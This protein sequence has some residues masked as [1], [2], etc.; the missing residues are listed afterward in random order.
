[1][2]QLLNNHAVF[3]HKALNGLADSLIKIFIPI[4]ILMQTQ[5]IALAFLFMIL[6]PLLFVVFNNLLK[7][8]LKR[9]ATISIVLHIL[10]VIAVQ[11]IIF[12]VP[13]TLWW[14]V[15]ISFL[16]AIFSV[17]YSVPFNLLFLFSDQKINVAKMEIGTNT[18]KIIFILI[19]GFV[20][21]VGGVSQ[22]ILLCVAASLL[23]VLSVLPLLLGQK[24]IVA[25]QSAKQ[26]QQD[27][28]SKKE[29][30]T[31]NIV[32]TTFGMFQMLMDDILPVYLFY[33][34]LAIESIAVLQAGVEVA[35][36]F[37]NMAANKLYA[38]QQSIWSIWVALVLFVVAATLV[39]VLKQPVVLYALITIVGVTFPLVFVPLFKQFC[40]NIKGK[41]YVE[42]QISVRDS[43]IFGGRPVLAATF[44]LGF[45]FVA[46]VALSYLVALGLGVSAKKLLQK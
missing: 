46:P 35:R 8:F 1:M 2:K 11:F 21:G 4:I 32:H 10:P 13:L 27:Q 7:T 28:I 29:Q 30:W 40:S 42:Q 5:N 23:Y 15:L 6:R 34:G 39:L 19:G 9:N 26:Q 16:M 36:V 3:I 20:I 24:N 17:F 37:A 45:T 33:N 38:K 31:F 14:I 44:F 18:G 41:S 22:L 25:F 12:F 43:F